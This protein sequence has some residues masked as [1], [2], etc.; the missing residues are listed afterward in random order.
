[1]ITAE[2]NESRGDGARH[3]NEGLRSECILSF[4][5]FTIS[6]FRVLM[7]IGSISSLNIIY[8]YVYSRLTTDYHHSLAVCTLRSGSKFKKELKITNNIFLMEALFVS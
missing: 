7:N 5:L 8:D 3:C 4:K 2:L 1:L 6:V